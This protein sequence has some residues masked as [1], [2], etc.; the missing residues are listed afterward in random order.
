[1]LLEVVDV[2]GGPGDPIHEHLLKHHAARQSDS[3]FAQGVPSIYFLSWGLLA[4]TTMCAV[5]AI[6]QPDR[7]ATNP[8]AE[9]PAT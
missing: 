8:D 1:M 2:I 3:R 4:L 9:H 7:Q 6:F 5:V